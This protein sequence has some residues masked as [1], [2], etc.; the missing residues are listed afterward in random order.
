M[1]VPRYVASGGVATEW[2]SSKGL[3]G[4]E[5]GDTAHQS[6]SL[7]ALPSRATVTIS[8]A[9]PYSS[10]HDAQMQACGQPPKEIV[11]E[12]APGGEGLGA[13]GFPLFGGGAEGSPQG[14]GDCCVQ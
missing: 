5:I 2:P 9:H 10:S 3:P 8:H 11:D 12:L 1:K 14:P 13:E 6:P 7:S 4:P